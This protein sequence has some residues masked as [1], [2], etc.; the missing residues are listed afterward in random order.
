MYQFLSSLNSCYRSS[1]HDVYDWH[2][3]PSLKPL[4]NH[5]TVAD[6]I[7]YFVNTIFLKSSD[8]K[9]KITVLCGYLRSKF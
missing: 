7:H 9:Q 2:L 5:S 3:V 4:T 6:G 1:L 8:Y